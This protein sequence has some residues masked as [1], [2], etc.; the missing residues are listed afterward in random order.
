[1]KIKK[2]NE[3]NQSTV[4]EKHGITVGELREFLSQ[5]PDNMK[6]WVSDR[7]N[8]EGGEIL[9]KV[10]KVLAY[11]ACLDGDSVDDEYIYIDSVDDIPNGKTVE[12]YVANGYHKIDDE[13]L[14]K[15]IIY[16]NDI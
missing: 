12:D 7:G 9:E 1:M 16:L 3:S 15:E 2:F 13:V 10:E 6:V 4:L 11:K 8:S 14:S 5:F